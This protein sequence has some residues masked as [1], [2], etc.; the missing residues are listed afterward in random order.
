MTAEARTTATISTTSSLCFTRRLLPCSMSVRVAY[1]MVC[2]S[3]TKGK[4]HI[5]R[6]KELPVH[7]HWPEAVEEGQATRERVSRAEDELMPNARK[8]TAPQPRWRRRPEHRPDEIADAGL[9]LFSAR[10]YLNVSVD[11]IA[12]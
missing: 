12:R 5:I 9:R 11:D 2:Y 7:A 8:S 4:R 10:G 3:V 6:T 1:S